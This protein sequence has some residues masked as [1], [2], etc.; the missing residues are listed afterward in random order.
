M[1]KSRRWQ[2]CQAQCLQVLLH[3]RDGGSRNLFW[4][5]ALVEALSAVGATIQRTQD[6]GSDVRDS[7]LIRYEEVLCQD[8]LC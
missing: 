7:A 4:Q 6:E 1:I 2:R 8:P 5:S 3:H